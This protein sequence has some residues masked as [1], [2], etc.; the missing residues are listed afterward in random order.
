M[1]L[2]AIVVIGFAVE[3]PLMQTGLDRINIAE[4]YAW[5]GIGAESSLLGD[6]ST[7]FLVERAREFSWVTGRNSAHLYFSRRGLSFSNASREVVAL[8]HEYNASYMVLDLFTVS[9]ATTYSELLEYAIPIG[10]FVPLCT[11]VT[12]VLEGQNNTGPTLSLMLVAQ[13]QPNSAGEFSRI[14]EFE[15]RSYT[16]VQDVD[17]LSPGWSAGNGGALVNSTGYPEL[18]IGSLQNYTFAYRTSPYDLNLK[19]EAGFMLCRISNASAVVPRVELWSSIGKLICYALGAGTGLYCCPLNNA[20]VGDIR[21]VAVGD[22]G[23]SVVI[24]SISFWNI[25]GA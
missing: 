13:T 21:V 4:R 2:I 1:L 14:F 6:E 20:A 23:G 18:V 10:G 25:E 8:A 7:I 3:Y 11:S 17:L 5:V 15:S 9:A 19:I 22:P 24:S 12:S 16:R